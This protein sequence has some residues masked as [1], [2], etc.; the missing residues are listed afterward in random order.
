MIKFII[1]HKYLAL[2]IPIIILLILA[3]GG[4]FLK[5]SND[6]HMFFSDDNPQLIAFDDLQDT[7]TKSDNILIALKDDSGIFTED[8]LKAIADITNQAW[9]VPHSSRVDSIANYQHTFADEDSLQVIDLVDV[10]LDKLEVENIK[11]IATNEILLE[12][13]LITNKANITGINITIE[14][15]KNEQLATQ[16]QSEVV[17]FTRGLREKIRQDYP[18]F[19]VYLSG[20]IML[21]NAF[22]EAGQ[23]D[24]TSLVPTAFIVV[25]ILLLI[26]IRNVLLVLGALITLF[27]TI[28]AAMGSAGYLG[29]AITPPMTSMPVIILTIAVAGSV[30]LM[31]SFVK[32]M[33]L[34]EDK[35]SSLTK[36]F[37]HNK[38][39][40]IIA[41]VTTAIGFLG[42]NFSEV[43]PFHDLGNIAAIGS[44]LSLFMTL[45]FLP[46]W[47]LSLP[48]NIKKKNTVS[49]SYMSDFAEFVIRKQK[50]ILILGVASAIGFISLIGNNEIND[51]FVEYFDERVEMRR[52]ADMVD[53]LLTGN[54]LIEYS[55]DS[56]KPNG[57]SDPNFLK[58]IDKFVTWMRIQPEVN[59]ISS[60]SDTFKRLNKNLHADNKDFYKLPNEHNLAAQY[61]LLY[62]MSLPYGLDLNNQINIDKSKT[63]VSI[64]LKNLSSNEYINLENRSREWLKNNTP[65]ILTEG[66]SPTLMFSH[67]GKRNAESMIYGT[68]VTLA[69]ISLI[70]MFIFKSA[71]IGI[72]SLVPNLVPAAMAFGIWSL[73]D[74][75]ITMALSIVASI[76][77][78]IIVD[79]T[80]HF[81]SKFQEAFKRM[82]KNAEDSIRYAFSHVGSALV[83]TSI[84]L[85]A[86]FIVLSDSVFQINAGMGK[87]TSIIIVV[88]L[89]MDFLLLPAL[90]LVFNKEKK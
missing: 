30:H 84:A 81:L 25:F 3:S 79:D 9:Q 24:M 56:R 86:G 33:Q 78:G 90:L 18:Q 29:M 85:T 51:N 73:I 13:R 20:V 55:F 35:I 42:L 7:Y 68:G 31:M 43:P 50:A 41:A 52:D 40:I 57:I 76:T 37:E 80:V 53:K 8:N 17:E 64:N 1:K 65:N 47:I 14:L 66:A 4:R 63:R 6:Y 75:Q 19:E 26:A 39:A 36:A 71:N 59:N 28:A 72:I 15:P 5:F 38:R 23:D 77:L 83:V 67:I 2:F 10:E 58:D 88:A 44:I 69:V 60:I 45:V 49:S 82:G 16:G 62:E 74:G 54:G 21:N 87:L 12:N 70:L 61:L 27:V 46:A 34:G 89:I 48:I 11:K 22:P 32:H